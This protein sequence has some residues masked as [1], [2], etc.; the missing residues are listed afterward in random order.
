MSGLVSLIKTIDEQE[1][2]GE[3]FVLATVVKVEGSAY[4][5]PGARMLISALGQSEGTV[6]GGCLEQDVIKKAWW[7]TSDG[8]VVRSYSTAEDG[9][10]S[11]SSYHFSLGCDGKIFLLFERILPAA[12]SPLVRTLKMVH[13]EKRKAAIATVISADDESAFV[14]GDRLIVPPE[15]DLDGS[16]VDSSLEQVLADDLREVMASG[17][18]AL[19]QY[20]DQAAEVEVFLEVVSPPQKLVLFG[21]GHDAQPLV[22]LAKTL[23]WHVTVIDGRANFAMAHRF[24][25]ADDVRVMNVDEPLSASSLLDG[26]AVV[27]MT[28]SVT[29][30]TRWL[31]KALRSGACY[32]GQL[33]PRYR[34]E[35][36]LADIGDDAQ[37]AQAREKLYYPVGLDLGGDTSESVAMAILSEISAVVNGRNGGMLKYR[38]ARIHEA[39]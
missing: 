34:T 33:G 15:G 4:R 30:D 19:N 17:K 22:R 23:G 1:R 29:Q 38:A 11:E 35:R 5:R 7:L 3:G 16:L 28:H 20:S 21:A 14:V 36:L 12:A 9:E 31:S 24:P 18:S 2:L 13:E 39:E 6:S 32:V 37:T 26:A 27:V 8:P 25:E 10:E